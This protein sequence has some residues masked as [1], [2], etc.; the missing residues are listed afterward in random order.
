LFK[1]HPAKMVFAGPIFWEA[2]HAK[3]VMQTYRDFL[4]DAPEDLG[5]F[6][7]LKTVPPMDPFP[8]EHWGKRACAL[9]G[10]YNG[11]TA[12]AQKA[13]EP[14]LKPVPPPLFNWMGEM[15]FPAIQGLFD[16]FFPKGLPDAGK[17]FGSFSLAD[18]IKLPA[19]GQ[20]MDKDAPKMRVRTELIVPPDPLAPAT[21]IVADLDWHPN[22][23]D[24]G[25]GGLVKF[26]ASDHGASAVLD[27]TARIETLVTAAGGNKSST[28]IDGSLRNFR[29]EFV[30]AVWV[31]VDEFAFSSQSG[32]KP[33]VKVHLNGTQ[34]VTFVGDLEFVEALRQLIPPG[35]LGDGPSLDINE[36]RVHAGFSVA[37]PPASVG[38]FSLSNIRLGAFVELPFTEGRPLFDFAFAL[39][40]DPFT[41]A[42][43]ILGGT[44]FFHVQLDT[45]GIRLLEAALEFGA[46]AALDIGIASVDLDARAVV[47]QDHDRHGVTVLRIRL[48][49]GKRLPGGLG[50]LVGNR[51]DRDFPDRALHRLIGDAW[52]QHALDKEARIPTHVEDQPLRAGDCAGVTQRFDAGG[53]RRG[54]CSRPGNGVRARPNGKLRPD[55]AGCDAS[56]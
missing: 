52:N 6:V 31:H 5:V 14:F 49:P 7:G 1:A 38:V 9:I 4:P 15:P 47:D 16:P 21:R 20:T 18:L 40:Q 27:I 32:K 42:V 39:R 22:V 24:V 2:T 26:I 25:N 55:P 8:K 17:L 12:D 29:V 35:L 54:S 50:E 28:Q 11:P 33:D 41:L 36:Q 3:S 43:A 19:G 48:D 13:L 30:D 56:A 23:S 10:A 34:P 45:D 53:L 51:S 37:L 44:G 46:I